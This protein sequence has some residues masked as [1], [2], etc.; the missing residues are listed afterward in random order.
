MTA[1]MSGI[2]NRSLAE[3]VPRMRIIALKAQPISSL[4]FGG[5]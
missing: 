4:V 2:Y 1:S 5:M 3:T